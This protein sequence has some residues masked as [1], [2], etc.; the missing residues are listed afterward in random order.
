MK[1]EKTK[2]M[3]QYVA[4][5]LAAFNLLEKGLSSTPY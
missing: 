3:T 1:N 2:R 5:C 4:A